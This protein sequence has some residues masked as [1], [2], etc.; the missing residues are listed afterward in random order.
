M[1]IWRS[2][3]QG[4]NL[5][6]KSLYTVSFK[7]W[8]SWRVR[9][10]STSYFV[11]HP[12][13]VHPIFSTSYFWCFLSLRFRSFICGSLY[14]C[15]LILNILYMVLPIFE[16]PVPKSTSYVWCF[17]FLCLPISMLLY[18]WGST[19]ITITI[20]MIITIIITIMN[21]IIFS[22][23][24]QFRAGGGEGRQVHHLLNPQVQG[25][26]QHHH[27]QHHHHHHHHHHFN[28]LQV[29]RKHS[30]LTLKCS[31]HNGAETVEQLEAAKARVTL[32]VR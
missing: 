30:G 32:D 24:D 1:Q 31:A 11:V 6:L 14:Q 25:Y 28:R 23:V 19:T 17:L 9:H 12:I 22:G 7:S 26:R 20:T 15:V 21:I 5:F 13:F 3:A 8:Q 29:D 27:R 16:V 18:K 4:P 10:H 2:V